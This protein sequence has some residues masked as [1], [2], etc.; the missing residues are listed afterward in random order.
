MYRLFK[1]D[2]DSMNV[3]S[4]L[5]F[6]AILLLRFPNIARN[7]RKRGAD[8]VDSLIGERD[9]RRILRD[10]SHI[11]KYVYDDALMVLEYYL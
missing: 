6:N 5:L 11:P 10:C 9:L 1:T 2:I 7:Y 8:I 3:L 4:R